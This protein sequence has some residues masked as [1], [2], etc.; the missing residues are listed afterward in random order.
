MLQALVHLVM[1]TE[2][3]CLAAECLLQNFTMTHAFPETGLTLT[4]YNSLL[5]TA[6]C[7]WLWLEIA[8][9]AYSEFTCSATLNNVSVQH[10]FVHQAIPSVALPSWP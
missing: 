1:S 9:S 4:G 10:L 5:V 7:P 2:A 3:N 6:E 8:L